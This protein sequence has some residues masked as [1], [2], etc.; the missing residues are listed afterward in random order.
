LSASTSRN[1]RSAGINP[2]VIDCATATWI[3]VG[4]H[5][6][7]GGEAVG[8]QEL[9][10]AVGDHLVGIHVARGA[11]SGLK[12]VDRELIVPLAR[13]NLAGGG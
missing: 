12:D 11:R 13:G 6:L 8:A 7:F 2:P 10:R 4:M 9:D 1:N 3:A 5:R